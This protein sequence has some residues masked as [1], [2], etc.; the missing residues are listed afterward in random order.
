MRDDDIAWDRRYVDAADWEPATRRKRVTHVVLADGIPVDH[1][2][3]EEEAT[4]PLEVASRWEEPGWTRGG[5]RHL[6][7]PGDPYAAELARLS[8]LVGGREA[9]LSLEAQPLPQEDLDLTDI[10]DS[11]AARVEGI[12]E[13]CDR[14]LDDLL[15]AATAVE[16][17]TVAR[18]VITAVV[19]RDPGFLT[20]SER[21]DIAVGAVC[22]VAARANDLAGPGGPLSAQ[23]LQERLRLRSSP[24]G[25]GHTAWLA[26]RRVPSYAVGQALWDP[27]ALLPTGSPELL[28]SAT[29][30]MIIARRDAALPIWNWTRAT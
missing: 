21:D 2:V 5:C 3:E 1:W 13:Q 29:R 22:W 16:M 6:G 24:A 14:I 27:A 18:R 26:C 20:R 12:V 17:R 25:R 30:A 11:L 19:R 10:A 7:G 28:T 8:Q 15:D 4:H 9:L 23:T